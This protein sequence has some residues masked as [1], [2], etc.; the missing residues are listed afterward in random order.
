[1]F[2]NLNDSEVLRRLKAKKPTINIL[3]FSA[4]ATNGVVNHL[5]KSGVTSYIEKNAGLNVLE[6]AI[7]LVSEGRSYLS[8][9]IIDIMRALM[10]SGER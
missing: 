8:P 6:Q 4:A 2:P 5:L 3:T 10:I 9:R 1:M 7:S